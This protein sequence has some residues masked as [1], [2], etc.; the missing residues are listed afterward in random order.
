MFDFLLTYKIEISAAI[1][2]LI[3]AICTL[4]THFLDYQKMI[5]A[6]KAKI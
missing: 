6:E 3:V 5:F 4:I 1:I 2:S